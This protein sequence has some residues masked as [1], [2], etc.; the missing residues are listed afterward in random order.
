M[1]FLIKKGNL[2]EQETSYKNIKKLPL[3]PIQHVVW[4]E[5]WRVFPDPVP[6]SL[7]LSFLYYPISVKAKDPKLLNVIGVVVCVQC[8]FLTRMESNADF[9]FDVRH[10]PHLKCSDTV[11]NVQRHVG[12]L[13]C[14]TV[15]ITV[16]NS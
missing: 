2:G 10:M 14:V 9:D 4:F 15:T 16:W 13:C 7:P 5:S 8:A 3:K 11:Q 1:L 12:H 6:L